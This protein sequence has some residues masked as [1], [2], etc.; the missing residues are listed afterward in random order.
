Q[1]LALPAWALERIWRRL[2]DRVHRV[3][4]QATPQ[5]RAPVCRSEAVTP[6][7]IE[8]AVLVEGCRTLEDLRRHTHI[9]GGGCDGVD[10]ANASAHQ[11]AELL[12]WSVDRIN[13]EIEHFANERWIG[14]R[15]VLRGTT[16]AQEEVWR[17]VHDSGS[18]MA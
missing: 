13:R 11:M 12:G 3:F 4:A 18:R 2:G 6:A 9:A 5:S 15:P 17:G 10:C 14:R 7:E 8:Y 1:Q 16:L